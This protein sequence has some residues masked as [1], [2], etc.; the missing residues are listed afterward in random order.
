M[1]A[2]ILV[3]RF[4]ERGRIFRRCIDNLARYND[5]VPLVYGT[6]WYQPPIVFARND[7][8]L[9][10]MEVLLGM[11]EIAG[12]VKV[13]V[14]DIEIPLGQSGDEHD[15]DGLV[16]PGHAAG[17]GTGAFN[18]DF[19]DAAGNPLGD[20]YGSMAMLSVVVPNPISNGQSLPTIEVLL[21]GLKLEQFDPSGASLGEAFT[22]NPAWVL[23]DVLRR[24][25][26]LTTDVDLA[27]FATAAAYCEEAIPTT[28]LY[29]NAI[30][31]PRFECNLVVEI[32]AERG[33]SGEGDPEWV[34]A[35]AELRERRAADAAGRE[36][37][38]A[39]AAGDA[40]WEQQ[41][42]DA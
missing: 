16:Q 4:G 23:L 21:T 12:V 14:N 6:A 20:P 26:W 13:V 25:G 19:A 2:Q 35:D 10:H 11:G 39:A 27:S 31:I 24:S 32:A 15:G 5:F 8:N 41:H 9:T 33:G 40:G 30:P 34:V 29:G 37:A 28:D 22:N 42:G 36:Y 17:R 1:P 7:G 3:R 38:G 18:P